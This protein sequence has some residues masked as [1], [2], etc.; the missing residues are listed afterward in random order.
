[1]SNKKPPAKPQAIELSQLPL[2]ALTQMKQE[3]DGDVEY[4]TQSIQTLKGVMDRCLT[5]EDCLS[6]LGPEAEGKELLVPLSNSVYV[7]GFLTGADKA[8]IGIGT[9]Y[10]VEK[11]IKDAKDVFKRKEKMVQEQIEKVQKAA[12][13]KVRLRDAVAETMQE[14]L[15]QMLAAQGAPPALAQ[16]ASK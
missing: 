13:D 10:Y 4:M 2:Q 6:K 1:M 15:M 11:D 14:K 5:S 12:Q 9:G 16:Q 3:L 8:I 7:P